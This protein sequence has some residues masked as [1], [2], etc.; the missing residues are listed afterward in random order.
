MTTEKV[1]RVIRENGGWMTKA[2]IVAAVGVAHVSS[3]IYEVNAGVRLGVLEAR[4]R[5]RPRAPG[6]PTS[7]VPMEYR[8]RTGA[9]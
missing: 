9:D 7:R 6:E 4:K 8:A 2:E 1:L 3:I 5:E